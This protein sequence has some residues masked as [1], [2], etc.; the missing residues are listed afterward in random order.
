MTRHSKSTRRV[1]ALVALAGAAVGAAPAHAACAG[2]TTATPFA[3]FGDTASYFLAPDGGF[4]AGAKGWTLSGGARV[5]AGNEPF[6]IAG[7]GSRS[8][9]LPAA[10]ASATSPFVCV[11]AGDPMI[12]VVQRAVA[13]AAVSGAYVS[14]YAI[15]RGGS[16]VQVAWLGQ[17][18]GDGVWA[19]SQVID[20]RTASFPAM[21]SAASDSVDVTFRF[22]LGGTGGG[23]QLDALEVDPF[24]GG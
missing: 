15:P 19:P 24:R 21:S 1:A 9:S 6:A 16:P 17:Q 14:V 7:A 3:A 11:G 12:R 18:A 8:L 22:V 5:V 23:F 2:R 13:T 4:E 20:I 10:G